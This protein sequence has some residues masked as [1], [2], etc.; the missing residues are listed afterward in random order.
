L[1]AVVGDF[2]GFL[3][4]KSLGRNDGLRWVGFEEKAAGAEEAGGIDKL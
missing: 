4:G 2:Q 3:A 1:T